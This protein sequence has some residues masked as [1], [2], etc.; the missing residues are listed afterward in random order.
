MFPPVSIGFQS[1]VTLFSIA[2]KEGFVKGKTRKKANIRAFVAN[3]EERRI[4]RRSDLLRMGIERP[5]LSNTKD[6]LV[7][8]GGAFDHNEIV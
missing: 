1:Q 8:S 7:A 6:L 5:I 3:P 4:L 2:E